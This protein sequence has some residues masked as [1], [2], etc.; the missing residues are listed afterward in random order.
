M[1]Y[2]VQIRTAFTL[3]TLLALSGCT[4]WFYSADKDPEVHLEQVEL[5]RAKLLEQRF[6]L[7]LRVDNPNDS[8][9]T[10][11]G[12][13]YKVYLGPVQLTEG[14][15]HEWFSVE[16]NNHAEF[17]VPIRTNLWQHVRPLVKLLESP[18]QPIPYRLEGTLETGLFFGYD[19]HLMRKGEII[20]GDFIPE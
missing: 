17:V 7:H 18:D 4:S 3:V 13:T 8:T 6:K 20:P 11:R 16:P 14:E 15:Y 9:L 10:V 19:V 5:I 1:D 2:R 12:L